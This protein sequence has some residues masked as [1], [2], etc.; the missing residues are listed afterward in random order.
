MKM[1][2]AVGFVILFSFLFFLQPVF[3]HDSYYP[4]RSK[5]SLV[6]QVY[7]GADPYYREQYGDSGHYRRNDCGKHRGWRH[8]HYDERY[9][10]HDE[11]HHH[12]HWNHDGRD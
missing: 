7:I 2:I 5:T 9:Y 12:G 6:A 1:R 4:P 11:R 3:G 10:C 8:R